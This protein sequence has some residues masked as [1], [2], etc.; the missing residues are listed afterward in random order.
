MPRLAAPLALLCLLALSCR[1]AEPTR[2]PPT[3][4]A[5]DAAPAPPADAAAAPAA[6]AGFVLELTCELHGAALTTA[7]T[8]ITDAPP[9]IVLSGNTVGAERSAALTAAQLAPVARLLAEPGFAAWTR[10]TPREATPHPG[11]QRC[12]LALTS[13]D[14]GAARASLRWTRGDE[15]STAGADV[16]R[17]LFET[18][19]PLQAVASAPAPATCGGVAAQACP[20]GLECVYPQD[21]ADDQVSSGGTCATPGAEGTRCAQR[22]CDGGLR[23]VDVH[24]ERRCRR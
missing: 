24:G 6:L 2:E 7:T 18:L 23:C 15:F 19:A 11:M 20:A 16:E 9:R 5:P 21:L 17:R 1:S 10:E 8:R 14:A 4:R 22:A 13:S 3:R 12:T